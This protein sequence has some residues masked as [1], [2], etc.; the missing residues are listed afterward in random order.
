MRECLSKRARKTFAPVDS[1]ILKGGPHHCLALCLAALKQR[2]PADR[3]FHAALEAEPE[4][5]RIRFDYARF[6]AE[7]GHEVDALKFLHE[8]VTEDVSDVSMWICGG[9]LAL[10]RPEFFEF[11]NDWT[12]ES[13]K[14]HSAHPTIV[15]QRAT[16]LLFNGDA[17]GALA[18]WRQAGTSG[19]PAR[20]AAMALCEVLAGRPVTPVAQALVPE[21]SREFLQWYRRLLSV[22]A[23][24]LVGVLHERLEQLR[25]VLPEVTR[26]I[27]DAVNEANAVPVK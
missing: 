7:D 14:L 1:N 27:G 22:N 4:S 26:L 2:E 20:L 15:E 12:G 21:V 23:G 18:V 19:S 10:R 5:R 17:D 16:A 3:A 25:P 11:A 9:Q 8:L 13:F 6:L 24:R